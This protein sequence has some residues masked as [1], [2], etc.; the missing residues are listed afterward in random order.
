[1]L[2]VAQIHYIRHEVNQNFRH[3]QHS[4]HYSHH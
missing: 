3:C 4:F 2:A 1:M